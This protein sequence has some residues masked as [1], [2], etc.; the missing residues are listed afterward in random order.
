MIESKSCL[1]TLLVALFISL[2]LLGQSVKAHTPDGETP[3]GEGICDSLI[4]LTPGLYGLCVA[5]CE[6][7]DAEIISPGGDLSQLNVPNRQILENYN[8]KKSPS[9]PPMPC[10][11]QAPCPCWSADQLSTMLPPGQ[12]IN[13][14]APHACIN[15]PD[16][17]ILENFENGFFVPPRI[18][19]GVV[20]IA[21]SEPLCFV[22]ND[23]YPGGPP[24]NTG[25]P[26]TP[27]EATSCGSSLAAHAN[28]N[29]VDG[30]VWD[31]F[32]P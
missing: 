19:T 15:A 32:A 31:C 28:A 3:A 25:I 8:R 9:D 22:L 27:G 17:K 21:P 1:N 20:F 7:H 4:G 26:I 24:T 11:Q 6:A 10:V 12:N 14:N 18:Q 16:A 5:Y 30:V 29:K 13:E 23:Q 2:P